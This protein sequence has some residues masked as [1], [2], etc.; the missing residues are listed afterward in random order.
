MPHGKKMVPEVSYTRLE[1]VFQVVP[2]HER[3]NGARQQ[4][5]NSSKALLTDDVTKFIGCCDSNKQTNKQLH[6]HLCKSG[7]LKYTV[8]K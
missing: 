7:K 1:L 2:F 3:V 4:R 8:C 5:Q 6:V